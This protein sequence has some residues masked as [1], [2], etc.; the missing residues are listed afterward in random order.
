MNKSVELVE[1][2][3]AGRNVHT[4]GS[5]TATATHKA[6]LSPSTPRPLRECNAADLELL[7]LVQRLF[8]TPTKGV[9][10]VLSFCPVDLDVSSAPVCPRT[11]ELLL[12]RISATVCIIDA[13][14]CP[15]KLTHYFGSDYDLPMRLAPAGFS[16]RQVTKG[17]Y[18]ADSFP[19]GDEAFGALAGLRNAFDF[20]FVN[21]GAALEHGAHQNTTAAADATI[22][23]AEAG[24]TRSHA[25]CRARK[26]LDSLGANVVGA[27]LI[28]RRFPIPTKVYQYL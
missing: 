27:L 9:P 7:N 1:N 10:Q 18:V 22:L 21:A 28:N 16:V 26:H 20:L 19:E 24:K 11:A 15:G 13:N 17:L 5:G 12:S 8:L 2:F 3:E 4:T 25:V 6:L 23:I 14:S